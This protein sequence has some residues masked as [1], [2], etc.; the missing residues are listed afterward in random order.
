MQLQAPFCH[1]AASLIP[2]DDHFAWSFP[3]VLLCSPD[4]FI[5]IKI[6]TLEETT[7]SAGLWNNLFLEESS[8]I[9]KTKAEGAPVKNARLL[10]WPVVVI[11]LKT[12]Q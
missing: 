7:F 9:A 5:L 8:F 3:S 6:I 11:T 12:H 1:V 2:P 4:G 10:T